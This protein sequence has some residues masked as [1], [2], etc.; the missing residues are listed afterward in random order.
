MY[1]PISTAFARWFSIYSSVFLKKSNQSVQS[2]YTYNFV[3]IFS[4]EYRDF[5]PRI[6]APISTN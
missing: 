6:N 4:K 3:F 5:I 1:I 2:A